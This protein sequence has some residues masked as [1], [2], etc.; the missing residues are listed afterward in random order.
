MTHAL[1]VLLGLIVCA[2]E[3]DRAAV[4]RGLDYL[5]KAQEKD[6]S[7]APNE[8]GKRYRP[9]ITGLCVVALLARGEEKYDTAARKGL[10]YLA[11]QKQ[12]G[13]MYSHALAALALA[14]GAARWKKDYQPAAERAVKTIIASQNANG[15]WGYAASPRS[16]RTETCMSGLML[17]ALYSAQ[18]AG[19]DVPETTR[20]K[21][22]DFVRK[23]YQPKRQMFNNETYPSPS[24]GATGLGAAALER[25][26]EIDSDIVLRSLAYLDKQPVERITGSLKGRPFSGY[27]RGFYHFELL[28]HALANRHAQKK[29]AKWLAEV[30]AALN[31]QIDA[32]GAWDGWFG[33]PYGTALVCLILQLDGPTKLACLKK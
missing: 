16:S 5:V 7:F 21:A 30:S 10:D 11:A 32:E 19:I 8:F 33:K 25:W 24:Y 22:L 14:E 4:T 9:G 6:G 17:H 31:K 1:P 27:A 26:G 18:Q 2:P 3:P 28:G 13:H 23:Q 12:P 15:G 29:P 20:K